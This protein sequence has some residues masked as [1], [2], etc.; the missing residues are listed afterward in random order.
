MG[1]FQ[2]EVR[3]GEVGVALT[4]TRCYRFWYLVNIISFSIEREI[5]IKRPHLELPLSDMSSLSRTKPCRPP[6]LAGVHSMP[7]RST[8]S[9]E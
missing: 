3:E 8:Q 2:R 9:T 7:L 6:C 4:H 1:L 5:E